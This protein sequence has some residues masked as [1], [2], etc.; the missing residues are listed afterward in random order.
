MLN[1]DGEPKRPS[2]ESSYPGLS[3]KQETSVSEASSRN[4]KDVEKDDKTTRSPCHVLTSSQ[5]LKRFPILLRNYPS[6]KEGT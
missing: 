3:E 2:G 6:E 4:R 5:Q 1:S